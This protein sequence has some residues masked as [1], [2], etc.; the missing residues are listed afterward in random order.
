MAKPV[1]PGGVNV[2]D[3]EGLRSAV[4]DLCEETK[5]LSRRVDEL[6][7]AVERLHGPDPSVSSPPQESTPARATTTLPAARTK[8]ERVVVVVRPLPEIAMAAMAETSLRDLPGVSEVVSSE[9]VEDWA[10]F[11]L[12]VALG[13]DLIAEMKQAMPV[14]FTVVDAGPE[15]ISIELRWAWGTSY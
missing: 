6:S 13:T 14:V 3:P 7:A 8:L 10:R 12:E 11:T 1:A 4:A 2:E 5:R 15:E 9:R